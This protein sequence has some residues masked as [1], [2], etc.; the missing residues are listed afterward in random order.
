MSGDVVTGIA[1]AAKPATASGGWNL[2]SSSE[3]TP[4]KLEQPKTTMVLSEAEAAWFHKVHVETAKRS[5][6]A[7][8]SA[9]ASRSPSGKRSSS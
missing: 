4:L 3:A 7:R 1:D 8:S 5:A 9:S 2:L 6:A